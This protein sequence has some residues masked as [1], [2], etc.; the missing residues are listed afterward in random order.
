MRYKR[1]VVIQK[2]RYESE[3][4]FFEAT[5]DEAAKKET[6]KWARKNIKRIKLLAIYSD[7]D[8]KHQLVDSWDQE[9]LI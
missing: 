7:P 2:D 6:K 9:D 8:S 1:L 5:D 4:A 3:I